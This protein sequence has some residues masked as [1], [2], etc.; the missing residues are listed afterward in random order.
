[1]EDLKQFRQWESVTPGHPE[2]DVQRGVENT[3]GPL[4]TRTCTWLLEQQ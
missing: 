2:L 1:M 4:G 3:S